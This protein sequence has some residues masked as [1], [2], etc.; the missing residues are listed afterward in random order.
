MT[1]H[2]ERPTCPPTP[3]DDAALAH[4]RHVARLD[5]RERARMPGASN[6]LRA[7]AEGWAACMSGGM[8]GD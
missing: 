5:A 6:L 1:P 4:A 2:D 3:A 7:L 8:M